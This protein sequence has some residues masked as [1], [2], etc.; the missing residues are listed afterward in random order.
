MAP[1]PGNTFRGRIGDAPPLRLLPVATSSWPS[2]C[3][4]VP[5]LLKQLVNNSGGEPGVPSPQKTTYQQFNVVV[6]GCF[7]SS[8]TGVA[9]SVLDGI[10]GDRI[11]GEAVMPPVRRVPPR[12]GVSDVNDDEVVQ[13]CNAVE[14]SLSPDTLLLKVG[15][16]P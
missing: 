13:Q 10:Q 9:D 7:E 12:D 14:L 4:V 1:V 2:R 3:P 15:D 8:G 6:Q 16:Q 11:L 5:E